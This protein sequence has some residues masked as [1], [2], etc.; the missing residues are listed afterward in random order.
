LSMRAAPIV[1][2]SIIAGLLLAGVAWQRREAGELRTAIERQRA[3]LAERARLEAENKLLA[4]AQPSDEEMEALVAKLAM[5]EQL[6]AQLASLRQREEAAA[7]LP[8]ASAARPAPSLVGNSIG[9]DHWRNVGQASPD[10]AFQSALWASANGDLD[11][12]AG[13]LTFNDA[14]RDEAA[15]LFARL[16][17]AMRNEVA[18]PERLIALLTAM[19]VPRGRAAILG[20]FPSASGTRVSA[21]LTDAEGKAKVAVFSLQADGDR[22]RLAVP[23]SVVKKYAGWLGAPAGGGK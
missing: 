15:A 14:A 8:A 10:A 1:V 23:A 2:L 21:Q 11:A 13:L 17:P 9:F 7:R 20:Q 12:L 22:W 19:D 4:A 16:P 6:R 3:G 18:T 5:A